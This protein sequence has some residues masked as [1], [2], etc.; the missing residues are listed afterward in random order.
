MCATGSSCDEC[1]PAEDQTGHHAGPWAIGALLDRG[2][3][4]RLIRPWREQLRHIHRVKRVAGTTEL[5]TDVDTAPLGQDALAFCFSQPA[6]HPLD[7]LARAAAGEAG[8]QGL[9]QPQVFLPEQ[10]PQNR[11]G[12]K[13]QQLLGGQGGRQKRNAV[14][15]L[16]TPDSVLVALPWGARVMVMASHRHALDQ[17]AG[18]QF[19]AGGQNQAGIE[20][21]RLKHV[22]LQNA[23]EL[24]QR[25]GLVAMQWHHPLVRLLAREPL[26]RVQGDRTPT[27]SARIEETLKP[28]AG[29]HGPLQGG[30]GAKA[31]VRLDFDNRQPHRAVPLKLKDQCAVEL[32][33]GLHEDS[34]GSHLT[35][36]VAQRL[37]IGPGLGARAAL[38]EV[39]PVI[40]QAH[41]NAADRQPLENELEQL[42]HPII[43]GMEMRQRALQAL[44]MQDV[45]SKLEAVWRLH[46]DWKSGL[47][48]ADSSLAL[49][50]PHDSQGT[51]L[52][53]GR[54]SRPALVA[55]RDLPRR[56]V[57]TAEGHSALIHA[58]AHIEFNA[59]NLALDALWRFDR[60][61]L[62][63][64]GD[65][66]EVARDEASH[67]RMLQDHLKRLGRQYGDFQAHDGLWMMAAKTAHDP[68][69]RMALVP[70]LLEARGLD[71]TPPMQQRLRRLG[72]ARG[73]EIMEVILRDEVGHVEVGNRWYRHLCALR[74]LDPL[75]H[76]RTLVRAHGAPRL[77]P[78]FNLAARREAGFD[79]RELAELTQDA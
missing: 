3:N 5:A 63:Y 54:P 23:A 56:S 7:P 78:P 47:S 73:V 20:L 34:R 52:L 24:I 49:A 60:M 42:R 16:A 29:I 33:I 13:A 27:V 25:F 71:A 69:A 4:R 57:G 12:V 22:M 68:L 2:R 18:S 53:P 75:A 9:E 65:W 45:Q 1:A 70:R 10:A 35:Q 39:T 21:F 32:D 38:Q 48:G 55:P 43:V 50:E 15:V 11:P 17:Q 74:G 28:I 66:L 44:A 19:I 6:E 67:F 79:E 51:P 72:D 64:Y 77:K 40:A 37:G 59:I 62:A 8:A 61:P 14:E 26:A 30:G 76:F 31:E 36:K 58:V 46:A 41:E